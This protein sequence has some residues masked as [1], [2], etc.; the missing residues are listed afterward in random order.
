MPLW[1][2]ILQNEP[3]RPHI[4]QMAAQEYQ[5]IKHTLY[6]LSYQSCALPF[7]DAISRLSFAL[8]RLVSAP[9]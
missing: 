7:V 5:R 1:P 6:R 3:D 8:R 9:S 2:D 4:F